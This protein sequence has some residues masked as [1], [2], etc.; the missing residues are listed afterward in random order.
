MNPL[1]SIIVPVYNTGTIL[2]ETVNSI[3][4]QDYKNIEIILVDDGSNDLTRSI[5]DECGKIDSRVLVYHRSNAGVCAARN[6]G[7][8]VANGDYITFSDHDDMI[9]Q[10][11]YKM[12]YSLAKKYDADIVIVG[13]KTYYDNKIECEGQDFKYF[14]ADITNNVCNI[15]SSRAI[16]NVW[17]ILYK[18]S[19]IRDVY[20]DTQFTRGQEDI[21]FNLDVIKRCRRIVSINKPL[22]I[23]VVRGTLSISAT[24]HPE[25]IDS[26]IRT[27]NHVYELTTELSDNLYEQ[28]NQYMNMQGERLKFCLA[29][30]I[31]FGVSYKDYLEEVSRLA[32]NKIKPIGFLNIKSANTCVYILAVAGK[33]KELFYLLKFYEFFVTR[34]HFIKVKYRGFK[35][36]LYVRR[37]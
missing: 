21:N 26:F 32:F 18:K 14:E 29:Y 4:K 3:L 22:Y 37:L 31:K 30:M 7:L 28:K 9:D 24:L 36:K 6:F 23:H 16:E 13:K 35:E 2:R 8:T 19:I 10:K 20:F 25:L 27:N 12:E 1:I 33:W 5:C 15:I 11:I 34:I 17:N